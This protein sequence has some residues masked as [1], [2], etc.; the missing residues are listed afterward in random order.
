MKSSLAF[1]S[2]SV[3]ALTCCPASV[4]MQLSVTMSWVRLCCCWAATIMQERARHMS[5]K[6]AIAHANAQSSITVPSLTPLVIM[7][8]HMRKKGAIAHAN[9]QSNSSS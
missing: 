1:P 2:V 6:R 3:D 5:K 7:S 8:C 4:L 9:A